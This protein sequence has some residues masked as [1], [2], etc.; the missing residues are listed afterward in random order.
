MSIPIV[1]EERADVA[2]LEHLE[3]WMSRLEPLSL[4]AYV[5]EAGGGEHVGIFC[6]DV[7][8]GF[9]TEGPLQSD[10]IRA[11]VNPIRDLMLRAWELGVRAFVLPQ[12]NHP[13]S[14]PEF[15]DYPPHCIVGTSECQT[16]PEL[17][18]LPFSDRFVIIPKKSIS[19]A[20]RTDLPDWVD[21]HPEI[22]HRIVVGDCTDL[23]TYQ[24]AIYLKTEAT[25]RDVACSVLV[26]ADCV[27]TYDIPVSAA[28]EAGIPPH[29]GDL[30]HSLFLYHM[31][32]NGIRV[33]RALV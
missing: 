4:E 16:V 19:S 8:V 3:D 20:V 15:S 30:F 11:I 7:I 2:F 13:P 17:M 28:T 24:L 26:P 23:C 21:R 10:R 25:A 5:R 9:C 14:S 12:D 1:I 31:A 29:P 33:V 27:D 18:S 6:V 32:L 22:T